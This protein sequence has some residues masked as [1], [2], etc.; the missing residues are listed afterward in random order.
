MQRSDTD[1]LSRGGLAALALLLAVVSLSACASIPPGGTRLSW[2]VGST[3]TVRS[4]DTVSE[5][6]DD[7]D[8]AENSLVAYNDLSNRD[9]I[10]VGQVL[11]I[12]RS[13]YVPGAHPAPRPYHES[14]AS[15]VVHHHERMQK[16]YTHRAPT[17]PQRVQE[18]QAYSGPLHFDWPMSGRV[19]SSFGITAGGGR[20]DGINIAATTGEPIRAAASGRVIYAGNQLKGYGN[21]V[22]IRHEDGYVT[23]YAHAER[24][25]VTRGTAVAKGQVIAF[26]GSTGNVRR[27]QLHFEIR[28]GVHPVN[29]RRLLVASISS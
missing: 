13:G 4:G 8:I 10:Y 24:L 28:R 17:R 12:P 18:A 5:I 21:L 7:Y 25:A 3:Y 2:P 6:A 27:P 11:R 14:Y 16:T 9:R 23:A 1:R 29:P 19:I 22:L 20:N 15:R 26:A